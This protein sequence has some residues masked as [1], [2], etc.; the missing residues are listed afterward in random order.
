MAQQQA[1]VFTSAL[2]VR[3]L[4]AKMV[5]KEPINDMDFE[6]WT[7]GAEAMYSKAIPAGTLTI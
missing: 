2:S 5:S 1:N 7:Q 4:L 6:D 3:G